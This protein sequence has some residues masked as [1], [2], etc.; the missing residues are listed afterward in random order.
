LDKWSSTN[1]TNFIGRIH[2]LIAN[3]FP[4]YHQSGVN[5]KG[6]Y[7]ERVWVEPTDQDAEMEPEDEN[8][9]LNTKTEESTQ[10]LSY[11]FYKNFWLVQKYMADPFQ[12]R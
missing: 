7:N 11:S 12:V 9:H 1:Q 5:F 6:I 2:K 10:K 8:N 4:L 3:V